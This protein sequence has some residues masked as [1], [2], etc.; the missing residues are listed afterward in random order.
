MKR[1]TLAFKIILIIISTTLIASIFG[2]LHNQI[3]YT[4]SDEFFKDFLF[5]KFGISDWNIKNN[6]IEASI[7]GILGSY[8]MGFYVGIIYAVIFLF[9][10]T[11]NNLKNI[12][13]AI[14]INVFITVLGSLSGYLIAHFFISVENSD[15]W[16]EFGTQNPQKYME[17]LYMNTGS[18]YG[19]ILGLIIAIFFLVN[20]NKH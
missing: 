7:I 5:G 17:A 3:S 14:F 4:I 18:Y 20:R 6:R 16:M 8:W 1:I 15:V 19:G 9:L 10:K 2:M 13:K 12:F 11:D